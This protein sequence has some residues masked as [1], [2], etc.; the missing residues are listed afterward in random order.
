[1]IMIEHMSIIPNGN[2]AQAKIAY[3]PTVLF[4]YSRSNNFRI[5]RPVRQ[6]IDWKLKYKYIFNTDALF[7]MVNMMDF[8]NVAVI[9][10]HFNGLSTREHTSTHTHNFGCRM[11]TTCLTLHAMYCTHITWAKCNPFHFVSFF[12]LSFSVLLCSIPLLS[13]FLVHSFRQFA[14]IFIANYLYLFREC[15]VSNGHYP[16][17]Y[18]SQALCVLCQL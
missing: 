12:I 2:D 6:A 1:M 11:Q 17:S 13:P 10:S 7:Q 8:R 5:F 3:T 14:V 18:V 4:N 9:N 16:F 15:L